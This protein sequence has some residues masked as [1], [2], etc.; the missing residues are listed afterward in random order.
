MSA[1]PNAGH[2]VYEHVFTDAPY[3]PNWK[4]IARDL[5]RQLQRSRLIYSTRPYYEQMADEVWDL[6]PEQLRQLIA[7]NDYSG[8]TLIEQ[9]YV[10]ALMLRSYNL[11][12]D[13]GDYHGDGW[14]AFLDTSREDLAREIARTFVRQDNREWV[15][16]PLIVVNVV[17]SRAAGFL[18]LVHAIHQRQQTLK[19]PLA[20][21]FTHNNGPVS[22]YQVPELALQK[23]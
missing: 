17:R 13:S 7:A 23:S 19:R 11:F 22:E 18:P 20:K 21:V 1:R 14:P 16:V 6:S 9:E 10:A 3:N 5:V 12:D 2:S 8:L 4:H 15:N